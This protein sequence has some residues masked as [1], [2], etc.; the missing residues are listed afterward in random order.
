MTG[1][2]LNRPIEQ[3]LV[4]APVAALAGVTRAAPEALLLKLRSHGIVATGQ[5]SVR[6]LVAETGV[7]ADRLLAIVFLPD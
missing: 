2:Q 4:D 6:D 3:A 1:H 7:E 5:Q